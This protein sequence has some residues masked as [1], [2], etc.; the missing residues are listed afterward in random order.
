MLKYSRFIFIIFILFFT[1]SISS[2]ALSAAPKK[3]KGF[4]IGMSIDN[5]LKNFDRL[6][7]EGLSIRENNYKQTSKYYTIRPGSGD[8]FKI[9]TGL[10][11]KT[12][13]KIYF[14]SAISDRLFHTKGINAE[15]F[16][17]NFMTAYN[18][19]EMQ[20]YKD[21]P[22]T[23]VIKGWEHYNLEYGFRIRIF[24]NKDLEIIRTDR[25]SDFSFD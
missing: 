2:S 16:K 4:F 7:F 20:P 23:N 13:A 15:I 1:I 3:I 24:L 11:D 21:N 18:I 14:S 10:N 8:P 25:F 17:K 9:E 22:G 12:V 6:G 19:L 5:A